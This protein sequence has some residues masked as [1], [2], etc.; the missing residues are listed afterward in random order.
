MSRRSAASALSVALTVLL[1]TASTFAAPK[2]PA[3]QAPMVTAFD[4]SDSSLSPIPVRVFTATDADGSIAGYLITETSAKPSVNAAGW[5]ATAPTEYATPAVGTVVLYAWAM[6]DQGSV[7]SSLSDTMTVLQPPVDADTLDGKDSTDFA[8]ATHSHSADDVAGLATALAGKAEAQHAHD[9]T[10]AR[11]Y[12]R[13]IVV[14]SDGNGDFESPLDA[15]NS[16]QDA[17]ASNP[18]LLQVMPGTYD[19]GENSLAMKDHVDIAGSGK[20]I[21]T[22]TS[23]FVG[24]KPGT[25]FWTDVTHSAVRDL[26]VEVYSNVVT[27]SSF[28]CAIQVNGV[29]TGSSPTFSNMR[30]H[31]TVGAASDIIGIVS[32]GYNNHIELRNVD[33]LAESTNVPGY[34]T[35]VYGVYAS[36]MNSTIAL[37]DVAIRAVGNGIPVAGIQSFGTNVISLTD[38]EIT[39]DRYGISD[40]H[41]VSSPAVYKLHHSRVAAPEALNIVNVESLLSAAGTQIDGGISSGGAGYTFVNCYD[42]AFAPIANQ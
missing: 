33:I 20:D 18:Y 21:T 14:D 37:A 31:A 17:S 36:S 35:H 7:S 6:D 34:N 4:V 28:L 25:L 40:A 42:G 39:S 10:Y 1:S 5:T 38:S 32:S 29:T 8:P 19:I 15:M 41:Y 12:N 11:K 22:I 23:T 24:T 9:G 13:V 16:I 30:I 26:T 3:N 2:P 27:P